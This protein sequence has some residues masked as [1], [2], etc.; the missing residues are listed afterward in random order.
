MDRERV[1]GM[2]AVGVVAALVYVAI[3]SRDS[4]DE[5]RKSRSAREEIRLKRRPP[6][7]PGLLSESLPLS[8]PA[9]KPTVAAGAHAASAAS[10]EDDEMPPAYP[11]DSLCG[12]P[13]SYAAGPESTFERYLEDRWPRDGSLE[14]FSA[15]RAGDWREVVDLE[16]AYP[17]RASSELALLARM[18]LFSRG[19]EDAAGVGNGRLSVDP[20]DFDAVEQMKFRDPENSFWSLLEAHLMQR[21]GDPSARTELLAEAASKP[22]YRNPVSSFYAEM[23]RTALRSGDDRTYLAYQMLYSSAPILSPE[24]MKSLYREVG[25]SAESDEILGWI[26]KTMEAA[27]LGGLTSTDRRPR[28]DGADGHFL[29][30]WLG[31]AL[32][33]KVNRDVSDPRSEMKKFQRMFGI[34]IEIAFGDEYLAGRCTDE[35]AHAYVEK[36]RARLR[37]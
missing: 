5:F 30:A 11:P 3:T 19:S 17:G 16:R 37:R 8:V 23:E 14:I 29:D 10:L 21:E 32:Q 18:N 35:M 13:Q 24:F 22:G 9:T 31:K 6:P 15:L 34:D 33:R 25:K 12:F 1:I 2:A 4:L 7:G 36:L 27:Q 28:A 26:G 20:R